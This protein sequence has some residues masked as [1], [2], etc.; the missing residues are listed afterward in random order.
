MSSRPAASHPFVSLVNPEVGRLL[1][2]LRMDKR[3][4]RGEG[5]WLWDEHGR[6]YLD[7]IANYGA[8]PFGYNPP[9]IWDA[10]MA[11]RDRREPSFVQ[12]SLLEAAGALAERLVALAPKPLRYVTFTNSGAEA[13]EAAIKMCRAATGRRR[14]LATF[15]SFH[16]KTLGAL[17]AT[18]RPAYQGPFGA[19]VEGFDFIPYGDASVLEQ[20]LESRPRE[21]AAFIVEPIQGEGGIVVPPPGY[22]RAAR[23]ITARHGVLLVFDEIQTGLGR[24]GRLFACEEEGVTP[25]VMT[26]AKALGGGLVPIGAC[27]ATEAAASEAFFTKHSSTFAG[28]ALACRA[29]LAALD[30]LTRDDGALLARVR[31]RGRQL[32]QGLR[33]IAARYP[34]VVREVRGRGLMLGIE[35]HVAPGTFSGRT[36]GT[37]LPVMSE[38]ELLTPVI[39]SHLLD[40]EGVRV[41]PTLNGQS[42][43]RIEPPLTLTAE[44]AGIAL[45]AIER[46]VALVAAG[47]TGEL[48][49]HLLGEGPSRHA[50]PAGVPTHQAASGTSAEAGSSKEQPPWHDPS[51]PAGAAGALPAPNGHLAHPSGDAEEGR[52]AFLVHPLDV[53]NYREFDEALAA[54]SQEELEQLADRFNPMLEP[55]V[56]GRTRF[57]SSAGRSAYGEFIVVPR[58]T[59]Q[60]IGGNRAEVLDLIRQAVL[61]GRDRGARI[62]GLGAYTAIASRGGLQ[63]TDLGVAVTTGN[64]YTVAAAIEA[65]MEGARRLGVDVRRAQAA[66]V[67]AGGAI[68]RATALLLAP[69]VAGLTLVG[70]PTSGQRGLQRLVAVRDEAAGYPGSDPERQVTV[71]TDAAAA[72]SEAQLVVIATNSAE[73]FVGP[74][75]LAAGAVVCDMSRPPN[76]SRRVERERPDV[77]V[78]DGGVIE[79]PG[80]PDFGWYFG[81]E[82]GLAYAC[83]S[84]TMMLALEHHY[85]HTSLGADLTIETIRWMQELARRHGFRL[86]ELRSFDRPITPPRWEELLA[87]RGQR[88]AAP[89]R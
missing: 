68:G 34:H 70:N 44:Q 21:Y 63:V 72:L 88:A 71:T 37:L 82:Q 53:D 31:E 13:I 14:I 77:L 42:V 36:P 38:Q 15:N 75:M 19:P 58:T 20:A 78:I 67:G 73:E 89:A 47:R 32:E 39:A 5:A 46:V 55:F 80:R 11:V 60:I 45:E 54:L 52:F 76:V 10:L 30:L 12:P 4:V 83:M 86:A 49:R 28:G 59:G 23:E 57:T 22:L 87:A 35:F 79:V 69:H 1:E 48:L 9:E 26:L 33:A 18:G 74:E 81:Y 61:L 16:G 24:T 66:V 3:F 84:E 51:F 6:R 7:C 62:V 29:G 85:H 27:L 65:L 56:I 25:D 40:V 43:I 41:A 2:R 17:S 50:G 8:L 64:S